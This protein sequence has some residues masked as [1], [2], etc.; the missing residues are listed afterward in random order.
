MSLQPR[1]FSLALVGVMLILPALAA[2]Q[3][4]VEGEFSLWG[5]GNVMVGRLD[6]A[7]PQVLRP[8]AARRWAVTAG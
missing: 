6:P 5:A 7:L 1:R 4:R 2:R 8:R 3:P